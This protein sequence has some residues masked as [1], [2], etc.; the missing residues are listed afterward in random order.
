[1]E[2]EWKDQPTG[3]IPFNELG[4]DHQVSLIGELLRCDGWQQYMR[5]LIEARVAEI[6]SAMVEAVDTVDD[7][8]AHR[9]ARAELRNLLARPQRRLSQLSK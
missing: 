2:M 6:E 9:A 1:M 3:N 5:P 8:K 7:L 4:K